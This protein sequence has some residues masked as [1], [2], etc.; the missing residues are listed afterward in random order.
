MIDQVLIQVDDNGDFSNVALCAASIG[1]KARGR[2][3]T[4]LTSQQIEATQAS[5]DCL[6]F[7]GV[8]VVRDY[9]AR[10]GCPPPE[11]DYPTSLHAFLGRKIEVTSLGDI[12]R[13]YN[14]PGPVVFVKPIQQ[15]L[16][17][18]QEVSR[19][20]DLIPTSHLDSTTPVY[21]VEH[22]EFISEWRVYCRDDQAVGIGHYRGDP[23]L[24]PDRETI[25]RA[26]RA[27]AEEEGRPRA[28]ALDF[29]VIRTGATLLVEANDMFALGSYGLSPSL[30]SDL[31]EY[32][33]EQL[34]SS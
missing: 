7:G 31:I 28:C 8:P 32:R 2:D 24:F 13:R 11:L 14:E 23:L 18:G 26:L 22:V 17:H 21:C 12:R 34:V 19:F 10:L 9:L 15:K 6:V 20:R 1:F 3:V 33:W 4:R 25:Q 30:Y 5:P 29:G 16:F 27:F